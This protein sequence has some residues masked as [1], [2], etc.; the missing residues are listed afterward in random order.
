MKRE[1]MLKAMKDSISEVLETM[2]FL[3]IDRTVIVEK[4]A[5][6]RALTD[7]LQLVKVEFTGH[8]SGSFMLLIPDE[9]ALF[10]TAS[11]LGVIEE[12]VLPAHISETK[13]EI[14]NMIAGNTLSNF[15]DQVVFNLGI[16]KNV[17]ASDVIERSGKKDE[18]IYQSQT[19]E[20]C[21]YIRVL[22]KK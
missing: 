7:E 15:N 14:V 22:I 9:L 5:F 13:K 17:C 3:P 21:L 2:F 1:E 10:L 19:M 8:F 20:R 12:R 6:N 4:E 18:V 16:P 11:F